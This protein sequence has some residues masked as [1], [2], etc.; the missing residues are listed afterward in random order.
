MEPKERILKAAYE[1][2][3][4][5]GIKSVTMDDIA[6][7]LAMSKKTIYQFFRDKNEVVHTLMMTSLKKDEVEFGDI[8]GFA[9]N[10]VEE[11]FMIMKKMHAIFANINPNIF[12]D[13]RK[14]H[15]ST[16][17]LFHRFRTE[18]ILKM[19]EATLEKG[20]RDGHV[21]TD[22]NTRVLARL[23]IEEIDMG[24]NPL[25]FPPDKFRIL[26][27]QL[28]LTE[29]FLYGICTLK[30]HKLINKYKQVVEED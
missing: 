26:D 23:R 6:K 16:W 10:V 1:L 11:V 20:K 25:V 7:H 2:F 30:G 15:P 5:Y 3:F 21:R 8:T 12:Y 22:V 17:D 28:A 18:F 14:Y 24:F 19:V 27:V 29:H 9:A 4:R 13:L